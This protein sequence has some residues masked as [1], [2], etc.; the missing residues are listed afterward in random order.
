MKANLCIET[1]I[2]TTEHFIILLGTMECVQ[3]A[4]PEIPDGKG[5]LYSFDKNQAI[6]SH[7]GNVGLS[8][9]IAFDYKLQKMYY[10]DSYRS[11]IDQYDFDIESGSISR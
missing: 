11:T 5:T 4:F 8:N 1:N 9:G 3:K 10:T 6:R 7:R 2:M